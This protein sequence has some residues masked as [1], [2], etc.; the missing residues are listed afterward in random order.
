MYRGELV[1][2]YYWGAFRGVS[3]STGWR[4]WISD[5]RKREI[6]G[7]FEQDSELKSYILE[8]LA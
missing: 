1:W 8:R 5:K 6:L 4:A 2:P 3:R 7:N